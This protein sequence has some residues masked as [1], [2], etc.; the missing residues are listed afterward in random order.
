MTKSQRSL[1]VLFSRTDFGLCIYHLF[2][3]SNFNFLH[4][5]SGTPSPPSHV[6][7][8]TLSVLI[9]F[10]R[11]LCIESILALILLILMVLFCAATRRDS[12]SLLR[13]SFLSHVH[14]FFG[15]ISLVCLL[16]CSYSCFSSPFCF[17]VIF[18]LLMF[19]LFVL[20]LVAVISLPA[21][22][23]LLLV[24]FSHQ[25]WWFSTRV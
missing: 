9:C 21:R 16:K 15:E 12:V 22:S 23:F 1:C 18:V 14:F 4:N 3:W 10:V 19:V 25:P 11:L 24:S 2:V 13:F 20:F 6:K 17:L 5:P 7:S 8:Y